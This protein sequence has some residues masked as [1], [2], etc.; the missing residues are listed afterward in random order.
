[1]AY[2]RRKNRRLNAGKDSPLSID[3]GV[4]T[5]ND[6]NVRGPSEE[7]F[8]VEPAEVVDIILNDKDA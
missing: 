8:Q 1:M 4:Q 5:V 2:K 3:R 6:S 7:F